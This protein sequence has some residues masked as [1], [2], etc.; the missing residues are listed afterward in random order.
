M[1]NVTVEIRGFDLPGSSCDP[2]P[3]ERFEN[4]H[5]GLAS[6]SETVEL[7]PGDAPTAR[8]T[9]EI[10]V[11][12]EDG[13]TSTSA[14]RSSWAARA[15]GT[16]LALRWGTVDREEFSLFRAA[17][18]RLFELETALVREAID[19]GRLVAE[20]DLTD[21]EGNPRCA[22]VRPPDVTWSAGS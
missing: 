1:P 18:L 12:P 4:I 7:V 10:E 19:T 9:F 15:S 5:V 20:I 17:K 6:R 11:R 3:G 16:W 2:A 13:G 21:E 8:W 14:G 22:T